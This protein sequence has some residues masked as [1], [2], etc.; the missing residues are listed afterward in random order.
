MLFRPLK[1]WKIGN[2]RVPM[3]PG[4]IPSRRHQLA[5]NIGEMVGE[6]LLT[7]DEIN[8]A[9]LEDRFQEHLQLM[10]E[11]RISSIMKK[12]L[13]SLKSITPDKYQN[14]L[15][16]GV[17]TINYKM[18]EA[19]HQYL[20]SEAT[21]EV[22]GR[23]VAKWLD[24][25]LVKEID[26]LLPQ[27]DRVS[28]WIGD[29]LYK[30]MGSRQGQELLGSGINRE[31]E[32]LID[33]HKSCADILPTAML[34]TIKETVRSQAPQV[35]N[36]AA[37]LLKDPEIKEKIVVSVKLAIEEFADNLG[38]MSAMIK[39]ML[40]NEIFDLKIR[41]FLEAKEGDMEAFIKDEDVE[42]RVRAALGERI[43]SMLSTPLSE[44]GKGGDR[45][46]RDE[47][48]A[49]LSRRII[50]VLCTEDAR[51]GYAQ[52]VEGFWAAHSKEGSATV[53]AFLEEAAGD[54]LRD[55]LRHKL[56]RDVVS[57]LQSV[58]A[59]RIVDQAVDHFCDTL[60]NRPIGRLDHLIPAG[61]VK[62]A[63]SSLQS[64]IMRLM[65]SEVPGIL[66]SISIKKIVAQRI[67]SFDLLRLEKLLLSIMAD[68]FRYINLFGA[69]IG[70]LIGCVNLFFIIGNA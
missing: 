32:T 63:I 55:S 13:G 65:I 35:L 36:Q 21:T 30:M 62:G 29:S 40:E 12:D 67:D 25:M 9:L 1:K 61:V 15:E 34:S 60:M 53:E 22:L 69:L 70:F 54:E 68:Q 16:I 28:R 23:S 59:M 24:N 6:H 20:R 18:K 42:I 27:G 11:S 52:V 45:E 14:Y 37:F 44:V 56:Q 8:R 47:I 3:T 2:I 5:E 66:K 4:V 57:A 48:A 41:Q 7:G 43:D 39:G 64:I 38:P 10:I 26:Q 58:E 50:G 46:M 31:F 51:R 17:K 49:G 33:Q 19:V